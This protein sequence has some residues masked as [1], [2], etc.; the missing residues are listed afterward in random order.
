MSAIARQNARRLVDLAIRKPQAVLDLDDVDLDLVVRLLRRAN[1]L[2]WLGSALEDSPAASVLPPIA[3]DHLDSAK[4]MAEARARLAGWELDRIAWAMR[5]EPDIEL[6]SMKGCTYLLLDLPIAAGRIF[7]DVD[8]LLAEDDLE[9]AEAV[10][11]HMGWRGMELTPYDDRYYRRWTHELPPLMHVEREVEIDLHHTILPRTARLKPDSRKLIE[12]ARDV[13]GSPYKV[14]ANED[15]VL[16]AMAHLMFDS[17]LADKLRDLVDIAGLLERFSSEDEEF[18]ERLLGRAAELDLGRPAYYALR[19]VKTLLGTAV[20][21]AVLEESRRFA[22]PRPVG[23]LMDRLVPQA[24]YPQHPDHPSRRTA[25]SRLLLYMRSH[26]LRMPPWLL[27][28]HLTYKTIVRM[29]HSLRPDLQ[30][31]QR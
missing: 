26:W 23:W 5:L 20:P 15:I 16:H 21:D 2:G 6:I 24:L 29:Q 27:A 19:Y 14:L 31:A 28:Y 12:N 11:N 9:R 18:W 25:L 22:P 7:A 4:V 8:L 30:D 13:P 1:L 10:L 3:I 17:D